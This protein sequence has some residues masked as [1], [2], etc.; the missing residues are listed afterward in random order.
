MSA[1]INKPTNNP[2]YNDLLIRWAHETGEPCLPECEDC[3]CDLTSR[4]VNEGPYGWYCDACFEEHSGIDAGN[5][6]EDWH[7][8]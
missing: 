5:Y 4:N 1:P 2:S 6:R 3:G 8:D 7:A